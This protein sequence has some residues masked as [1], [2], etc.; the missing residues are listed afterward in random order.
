LDFPIQN[1]R[2]PITQALEVSEIG[3]PLPRLL[4]IEVWAYLGGFEELAGDTPRPLIWVNYNDFT[5]RPHWNHG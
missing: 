3:H 4:S 5:S 1:H 2:K